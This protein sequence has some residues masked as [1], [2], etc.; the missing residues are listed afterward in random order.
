MMERD[1]SI[2]IALSVLRGGFVVGRIEPGERP[3]E[4]KAKIVQTVKGRREVGVVAIA[5]RN[6]YIFVKTVEWEDV[7]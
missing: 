2:R 3:G 5:V 4:W 6:D 7:R 1:I